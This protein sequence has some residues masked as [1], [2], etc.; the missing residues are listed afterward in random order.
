L[1]DFDVNDMTKIKR[2]P[3]SIES[4]SLTPAQFLPSA[5]LSWRAPIMT[6]RQPA[7]PR[8]ESP[9]SAGPATG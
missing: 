4:E 6:R 9:R 5:M 1:K 8:P 3:S 2:P 7:E